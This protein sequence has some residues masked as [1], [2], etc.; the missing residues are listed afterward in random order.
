VQQKV[1]QG[2][3]ILAAGH[4]EQD[5]VAVAYHVEITDGATNGAHQGLGRTGSH[6]RTLPNSGKG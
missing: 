4:A 1:H 5:A 6:T 2:K 3:R